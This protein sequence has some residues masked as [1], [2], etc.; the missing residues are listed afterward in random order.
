MD[1]VDLTSYRAKETD[2][3]A[4]NSHVNHP[5]QS[6]GWGDFRKAMGVNVERLILREKNNTEY[7]QLTFHRIPNTPWT[8]GYFPKGPKLTHGMLSALKNLG[9]Q[10]NAVYIQLEP[11]SDA[12]NTDFFRTL[13]LQ[14]SHHPLF[15]KYTFILDLTLTEAELLAR[16]HT[17]TRYN[18]RVAQ[19]HN[20]IVQ[21]DNSDKAFNEY[22]TLEEE[23]TKRQGF[24]A[25]SRR[26]HEVMWHILSKEGIAKLWT[27][28]WNN[29]ILS[30]WIIFLWK[31]TVYYPYGASSRENRSVMAPTL[32]L[33]EI[34][35]WARKEGFKKFDL[36]GSL[37]PEPD[38]NDPWY[39]FH[40]FKQGFN[41]RLLEFTG[42]FDL[43]I[44]RPLYW[45]FTH[46]NTLRWKILSKIR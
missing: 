39:G 17:K 34:A 35:Q 22:L 30:A 2:K 11:N 45:G 40:R 33:W 3:T 44:Q 19:K 37:G 10:Q 16:M 23:T 42:S 8:I 24:Y 27:A 46:A 25:H 36:W 14:T 15:T 26:Y 4:W 9:K 32:M 21:E 12:G 1:R 18:I 29:T 13:G 20:V 6:W 28:T 38:P 5:L 31:D 43:P 7:W 41:P